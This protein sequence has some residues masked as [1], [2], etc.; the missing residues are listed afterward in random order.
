M[1]KLFIVALS[2]LISLIVF[3]IWVFPFRRILCGLGLVMW[4]LHPAVASANS[5]FTGDSS[6]LCLENLTSVGRGLSPATMKS[7]R[8]NCNIYETSLGHMSSC[9]SLRQ[10][11][12][13]IC[14]QKEVLITLNL[15]S[16][17]IVPL[18][19]YNLMICVQGCEREV[20]EAGKQSD[21]FLQECLLRLSWAL[22]H[23]K[24]PQ[25]VQRGIAMLEGG[26]IKQTLSMYIY[27]R[28]HAFTHTQSP[29]L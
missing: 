16:F 24:R 21:E 2:L 22:V 7:R 23:S 14:F 13:M 26:C 12:S 11:W 8:S 29:Y 6:L 19:L 4:M 15:L 5:F 18:L 9:D 20:A 28:A 25:D 1:T 17:L 10:V 27:L 3:K